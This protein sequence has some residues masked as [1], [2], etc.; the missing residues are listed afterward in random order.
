MAGFRQTLSKRFPELAGLYHAFLLNRQ[1]RTHDV[2][3]TPLGFR[4]GGNERMQLGSFEPHE[5]GLLQELV[6]DTDVFIDVGANIGYYACLMR[7]LGRHVV[8]IEPL[9]Q[10]LEFL[11]R[12]LKENGWSDVEVLPLAMAA[13]PGISEIYGGGTGASL[14]SGWAGASPVLRQT[15]PVNTLDNV[16]G[17]RFEG[18]RVL[19]K[20]DVEGAELNVLRGAT[21]LLSSEPPPRWLI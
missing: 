7:S 4:F 20:I 15:V 9:R 21:H 6:D 14:I 10:N 5:T 2:R 13:E 17:S 16:V 18:G 19:I 3:M 12:N 11:L 8:A 1:M